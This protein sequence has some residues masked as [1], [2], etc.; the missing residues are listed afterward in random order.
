VYSKR[1]FY[2]DFVKAYGYLGVANMRFG[3]FADTAVGYIDMC[4]QV[5][6]NA[7]TT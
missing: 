5:Y 7:A 1:H 4:Y 6:E 2:G 3:K